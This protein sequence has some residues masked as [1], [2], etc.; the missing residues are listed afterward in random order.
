MTVQHL[1]FI[2]HPGCAALIISVS[3]DINATHMAVTSLQTDIDTFCALV[4]NTVKQ[5]LD[6]KTEPG[7]DYFNTQVPN[8]MQI[9]QPAAETL[10]EKYSSELDQSTLK[11]F[12]GLLQKRVELGLDFF[13]YLAT[14]K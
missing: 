8:Y 6:N 7:I 2:W 13:H 12:G 5:F 14:T 3:L 1:I 4:D 11:Q 10:L 9:A